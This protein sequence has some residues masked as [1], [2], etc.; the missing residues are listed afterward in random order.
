MKP[1]GE[2]ALRQHAPHQIRFYQSRREQVVT[3]RFPGRRIIHVAAKISAAAL[4]NQN[5]ELFVANRAR[6]IER[7]RQSERSVRMHTGAN[8]V[9]LLRE[10]RLQLLDETICERLKIL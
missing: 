8:R 2:F 4:Y 10:K 5:F 7:K 1:S 9:I 3:T 6:I